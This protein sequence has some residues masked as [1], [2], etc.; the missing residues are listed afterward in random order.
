VRLDIPISIGDILR[1]VN[2]E[3]T[4]VSDGYVNAVCTD[5]REVQKTDLFVPLKGE[6]ADG[7]CF[8]KDVLKKGC[9]ALT[10]SRINGGIHVSNTEDALLELSKLYKERLT[11]Y[12]M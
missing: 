5:S 6:S 2:A 1:A 3:N 8:V 4:F 7:E 9:Y 11:I 12:E 10:S